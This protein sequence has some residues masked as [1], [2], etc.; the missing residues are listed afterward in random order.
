M[1]RSILSADIRSWVFV[2]YFCFSLIRICCADWFIR[3]RDVGREGSEWTTK[4]MWCSC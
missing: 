1:P 2:V 3:C 4:S